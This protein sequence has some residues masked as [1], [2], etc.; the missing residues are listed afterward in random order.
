MGWL[1]A[2]YPWVKAAHIAFVIFW[3][4][5]LFMLPRFFIYHQESEAGSTEWAKWVEREARLIRIILNPAMVIAWTFGLM[6]AWNIWAG[7]EN[8]FRLKIIAV[9]AL[10]AYHM[11]MINYAKRL[12]AGS[13]PLSGKKL[14]LINEVPGIAAI[15]IVIL[16]VVRPF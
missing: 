2:A 4:A 14:R 16:A 3:M 5:G 10:G 6:L 13:M 9:F 1:G 7:P 11:W 15:I 8:W 12:A